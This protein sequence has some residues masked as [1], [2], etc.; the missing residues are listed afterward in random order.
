MS[1]ET[2][3]PTLTGSRRVTQ[4]EP[5]PF[6]PSY[7]LPSVLTREIARASRPMFMI[8]T[9]A[10]AHQFGPQRTSSGR[11]HWLST[12]KRYRVRTPGNEIY[13]DAIRTLNRSFSEWMEAAVAQRLEFIS[14]PPIHA[15]PQDVVMPILRRPAVRTA[16]NVVQ[17]P[18]RLRPI[19][20]D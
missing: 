14:E 5:T 6:S 17:Q 19:V 18:R 11:Q 4:Y 20:F 8:E 15:E 10:I 13:A 2:H 9:D 16:V 12:F 1:T 7:N 3:S